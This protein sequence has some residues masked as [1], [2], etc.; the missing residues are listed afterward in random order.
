M[1]VPSS[2]THSLENWRGYNKLFCGKKIYAGSQYYYSF[3]TI[4]Y[5]LIY[6][7]SFI[8]LVI[9]QQDSLTKKIIYFFLYSIYLLIVIFFCLMCAFTDP[10]VF[11]INTLTPNELKNANCCSNNRV[12]YINGIR[13][14]KRFCYTCQIIRP[15]GSSHCKTCNICVEKF[16]HHCP[17][18]GNCIGKNNYKFFFIFLI[19]LNSFFIV[20]L[21]SSLCFIIFNKK[22]IS[23]YIVIL[24]VLTMLFITTLL[25]Y[26][27]KFTCRNMSTYSNLKMKDTF[28]LFGNPFS[29]RNCKKN[30]YLTLFKKYF[31]RIDFT[32]N[33]KRVKESDSLISINSS[34]SNNQLQHF[35]TYNSHKRTIKNINSKF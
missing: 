32:T 8:V 17:W 4:L 13:H 11:P 29:R 18:V 6:G 25:I 15:I 12:F 5:L 10:G 19:L 16:D 23:I 34:N 14:R 2:I 35:N 30:C 24:S 20:T 31:K 22:L 21:I 27:I 26:H 1:K 33:I 28:I 7:I 9:F 3:G